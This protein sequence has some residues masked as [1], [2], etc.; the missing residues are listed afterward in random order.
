MFR[1]HLTSSGSVIYHKKGL[2]TAKPVSRGKIEN[3][4][5][6]LKYLI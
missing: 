1:L 3:L 5:S 2:N 4:T 6:V